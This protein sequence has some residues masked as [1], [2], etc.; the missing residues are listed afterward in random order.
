MCH[1][2]LLE[3]GSFYPI[4]SADGGQPNKTSVFYLFEKIEDKIEW[5]SCDL[6]TPNL[7]SLEYM[8]CVCDTRRKWLL[9][10][11]LSHYF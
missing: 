10:K 9:E 11:A 5:Q 2:S 8:G 3:W 7:R 6:I 1:L 4:I